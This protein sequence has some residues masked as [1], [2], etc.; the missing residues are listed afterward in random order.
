MN[1][2]LRGDG[3]EAVEL[4][5]EVRRLSAHQVGRATDLHW[6]AFTGEVLGRLPKWMWRL[7]RP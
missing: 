1:R 4:F 3:A 2:K 5:A 7:G 6:Q